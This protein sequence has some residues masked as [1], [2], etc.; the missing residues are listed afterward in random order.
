MR[1]LVAYDGSPAAAAAVEEAAHRQWPAGSQIHLVMVLEWPM[2]L[3]PQDGLEV[4]GMLTDEARAPRKDAAYR[5]L[6]EAVAMFDSRP[7]LR[8][9]YELREGSVKHALL[10]AVEDWKADLVLAGSQGRSALGTL[11]VGSVCHALVSHAPCNVE[12]IKPPLEKAG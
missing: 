6:Q 5:F 7:D 11:F 8:V 1:V 10:E 3:V 4:S 12:V 9:T 2:L